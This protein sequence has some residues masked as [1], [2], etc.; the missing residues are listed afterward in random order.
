[1]KFIP[2]R[3]G[4]AIA[5]LATVP[6]V[7]SQTQAGV[8]VLNALG[9]CPEHRHLEETMNEIKSSNESMAQEMKEMSGKL[10]RII[11]YMESQGK[12]GL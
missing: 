2:Q 8:P 6:A 7:L 10:N 9:V 3:N 12:M 5:G 1:M 11:G 4:K